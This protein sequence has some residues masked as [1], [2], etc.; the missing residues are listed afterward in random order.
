MVNKEVVGKSVADILSLEENKGFVLSRLRREDDT[1]L[2][3]GDTV[4]QA[5]DLVV[6]VGTESA[7]RRVRQLFGKESEHDIHTENQEFDFRRI[8]VSDGKVAGK[9]IGELHLQEMLDATITRIRR[10]DVDFVPSGDTVLERGDRVR[11]LTWAGN[12]DR[13]RRFFGD[14]I[15][16]SSETDFFRSRLDC[17]RGPPGH[18]PNTASGRLD[19]H[20]RLRRRAVDRGIGARE[21]DTN[22]T[23]HLGNAL[24]SQ[25]DT[26]ANWPGAVLLA[27]EPGRATGFCKRLRKGDGS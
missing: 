12:I 7:L 27:S 8:E 15:R 5:G 2:V 22:R 26:S 9:T 21:P 23:H 14:S 16:S 25:P 17:A 13:L 20:S 1:S 3:Y 10:G 18:G 4:L 6:A 11:V 24:R 19:V